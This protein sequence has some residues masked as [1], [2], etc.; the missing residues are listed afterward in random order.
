ML[1]PKIIKTALKKT[2]RSLRQK[3]FLAE[4]ITPRLAARAWGVWQ[5]PAA[6]LKGW[7]ITHLNQNQVE[8]EF[9]PRGLNE[10]LSAGE[11]ALRTLWKK[12]N[13]FPSE[14]KATLIDIQNE[15]VAEGFVPGLKIF[16]RAESHEDLRKNDFLVQ[17]FDENQI[18]VTRVKYFFKIDLLSRSKNG[19]VERLPGL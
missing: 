5:S 11:F 16:A 18:M 1:F 8:M 3:L 2:E 7:R 19:I 4:K 13:V 9:T 17:F 12:Q 14:K 6:E 10:I 15:S